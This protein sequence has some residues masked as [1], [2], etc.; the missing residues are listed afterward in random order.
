MRL[1]SVDMLRAFAIILMVVVHFMENLSGAMWNLSGLSAPLFTF[2]TGISYQVWLRTRE[3]AGVDSDD[4]S[5]TT[6]RRGLFLF[7]LGIVFNIVV[8]LPADV[9]NWDILTLI[10][11][12]Y[13]LFNIVRH[14][15]LGVALLMI[16][17][18]FTLAPM[19]RVFS[20]YPAYWTHGYFDCDVNAREATLG[21]LVN[22]FFPIFPWILY[23]LA[24]FVTGRV[25]FDRDADEAPPWKRTAAIGIGLMALAYIMID[26]QPRLANSPMRGICQ[27]WTMFPA[28][29]EYVLSTLGA[30]LFLFAVGHRWIDCDSSLLNHGRFAGIVQTF[31]RH[32]LSIYLL[33]HVVHLW[34]LWI[35]GA[36]SGGETTRLWRQAISV[37]W[38][39]VWSLIFLT[40]CYFLFRWFDRTKRRGIEGWMR[41]I[42]DR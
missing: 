33:H 10:G 24:G 41:S 15:P 19:L 37:E 27:G 17:C 39:I 16:G 36:V 42:C 29:S 40:M 6:I 3:S 14:F 22:G 13:L 20:D 28:S 21:F 2:L 31:S 5:R 32:S 4:I 18:A 23:P 1:L 30:T 7:T 34:P 35:F 9:F 25:Y 8:W 38:A 12:G 26:M 11:V